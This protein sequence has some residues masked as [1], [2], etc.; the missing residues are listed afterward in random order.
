MIRNRTRAD[1]KSDILISLGEP[2]IKVNVTNDQLDNCINSAIKR[3]WR[4]HYDGSYE[5][6]YI[7]TITALDV[8]NGYIILPE[9]V[10]N[11][12]SVINTASIGNNFTTADWQIKSSVLS[13]YGALSTLNLS[14]YV[15]M[16]QRMIN[17]R[18]VLGTNVHQFK[19]VSNQK[20]LILHFPL[21]ENSV[22]ALKTIENVD[23]ESTNPLNVQSSLMWDDDSLNELAVALVKQ[24]W[25]MIMRRF[26]GMTLPGGVQIDG[27]V[28]V[29]EGKQEENDVMERWKNENVVGFFMG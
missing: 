1:F 14:D 20:R 23:P 7:Y 10:D 6:S 17:T 11:V 2:I 25:G 8:T 4:W 3:Y 5:T 21:A 29:A 26:N 12:I 24:V 22:I 18:E 27:D 28:L 16:Q 19:Y 9:E 13:S 15:L